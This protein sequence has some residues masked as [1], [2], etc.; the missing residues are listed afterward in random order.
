MEKRINKKIDSYITLFKNNSIEKAKSIFTSDEKLNSFLQFIYDY[1]RLIIE[2]EDFSKRKRVKN[3][4]PFYERCCAK[5]A[6]DLQCTR[7]KKKGEEYCGTHLK[8]KP[9]GV[10][11]TTNVESVKEE[12]TYKI[13]VWTQEIQGICYYIDK[14]K[15]VYLMEDIILNKINPKIIAK[16]VLTENNNYSIPELGI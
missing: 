8:N 7:R 5:R 11:E 3:V 16:Y 2:K 1:E 4:V 9:F 14:Y 12:T 15:N 6:N 13:E 10:V